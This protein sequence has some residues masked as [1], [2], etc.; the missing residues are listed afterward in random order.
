M[1]AFIASITPQLLDALGTLFLAALTWASVRLAAYIYAHTK[2]A[3]VQGILLRLNDAVAT[4]V[5]SLEQTVVATAKASAGNGQLTCDI[6]KGVKDAAIAAIKLHLGPQGIGE[7]RAILGVKSEDLDTFL[8][9][10]IESQVLTAPKAYVKPDILMGV[11]APEN[12]EVQPR[13]SDGGS[14]L[15][16][17]LLGLGLFAAVAGMLTILLLSPAARAETPEQS[18]APFAGKCFDRAGTVCIVPDLSFSV[19]RVRLNGPDSGKADVGAVPVGAGWALLFG[20]DQWWASG[21]ALHGILDFSQVGSNKL[22]ASLTATIFRFGHAGVAYSRLDGFNQWY[23]V[24]GLSVPIDVITTG[25]VQQK[26]AMA[27]HLSEMA[28]P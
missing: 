9:E 15:S 26:R 27:R 21:A 2:N 14:I 24:A 1:K 16:L 13:K 8:S 25:N 6:A 11:E 23:G 20:Y 7:L 5:R 4:A 10:R 3:R 22:E 28:A 17:L 19:Y 12:G 18:V